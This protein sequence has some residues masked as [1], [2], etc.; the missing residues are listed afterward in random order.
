MNSRTSGIKRWWYILGTQHGIWRKGIEKTVKTMRY[1]N[2]SF[3]LNFNLEKQVV[4][5]LFHKT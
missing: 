3:G 4:S 2:Q 5:M 1:D